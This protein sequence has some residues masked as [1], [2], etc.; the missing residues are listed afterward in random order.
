MNELYK[1]DYIYIYIYTYIS[2]G[3][4]QYNYYYKSNHNITI[5]LNVQ[6]RQN[7]CVGEPG[8]NGF[9]QRCF[10]ICLEHCI[11]GW[12]TIKMTIISGKVLGGNFDDLKRVSK[13]VCL[14]LFIS[15]LSSRRYHLN[16]TTTNFAP[17]LKNRDLSKC[18]SDIGCHAF[19]LQILS[20]GL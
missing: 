9:L 4:Q 13:I 3:P 14:W 2:C 10:R 5:C 1:N 11:L 17:Q 19:V 18:F 15:F 16:T 8:E 20:K 12:T 7:I 6:R